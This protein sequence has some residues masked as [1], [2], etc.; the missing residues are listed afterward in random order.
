MR[1]APSPH[2][3]S[4]ELGRWLGDNRSAIVGKMAKRKYGYR[5]LREGDNPVD[6]YLQHAAHNLPQGYVAFAGTVPC[7][8]MPLVLPAAGANRAGVTICRRDTDG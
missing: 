6:K 5:H 7:L 3:R 8:W 1:P 2:V 4:V